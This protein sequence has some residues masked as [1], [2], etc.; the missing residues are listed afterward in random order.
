LLHYSETFDL[1][2][3]TY[4]IYNTTPGTDA[5]KTIAVLQR[6]DISRQD[7]LEILKDFGEITADRIQDADLGDL[8]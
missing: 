7:Q 6:L 2:W 3:E 1:Y 5:D 4:N 8:L